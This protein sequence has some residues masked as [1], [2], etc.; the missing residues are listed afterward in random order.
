V[1]GRAHRP[2]PLQA[3]DGGTHVREHDEAAARYWR[4]RILIEVVKTG[5]VIAWEV[6]KGR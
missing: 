5:F 4:T 3:E 6:I 2:A 1:I